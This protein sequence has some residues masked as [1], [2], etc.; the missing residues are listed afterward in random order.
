MDQLRNEGGVGWLASLLLAVAVTLMATIAGC[1][2]GGGPSGPELVR[3]AITGMPATPM[4]P[5]RTAQLTASA[6]YS[7]G[8]V[9]DITAT[10][11]WDTTDRSVLVVSA[12]GLVTATGPGRAE[13]TASF[14]G[15]TGRA[16]AEVRAPPS[17]YYSDGVE[18][19]FDYQLDAQGRVDSYRITQRDGIAYP[20]PAASD[21]NVMG[22]SASLSGSYGCS[23]GAG[24]MSGSRGRL[25]R[26]GTTA[27]PQ[28][29]TYSYD[30]QQRLVEIYSETQ[31]ANHV[32]DTTSSTLTYDA[33]G[34]VAQ[35]SSRSAHVEAGGCSATQSTS[36][37]TL[38]SQSRLSQAEGS[39][40]PVPPPCRGVP[41]QPW[42]MQWSYS[43]AG[44]LELALQPIAD[45]LGAVTGRRTTRYAVDP[46]G[47]LLD[48]IQR[49]E[50][51]D[52]ITSEI[53]DTY[54]IV[55][56]GGKVAEE[57]FTQAEPSAFY[58][59]RRPQRIRYE[60]GRLPT[61]PLFVPRA[62]TGLKGADYF[63]II[64]SHHR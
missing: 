26:I 28:S 24:Y 8:M 37:I 39:P 51:G 23:R 53:A 50:M 40:Q 27:F 56:F 16:S 45:E 12:A 22:C 52:Q 44:F 31:W 49:V 55:R 33:S 19:A 61:E 57:E 60:W 42:T 59:S 13:V 64:S 15:V 38:D 1:G 63:G 20:K 25:A 58:G 48:R 32:F 47:W 18:Y 2:G 21:P 10:A 41:G 7:D 17:A 54:A 4:A 29:T 34:H 62:L 35:V 14:G 3:V 46:E 9:T 43:A 6:A 36:R 5:M 11:T 30:A